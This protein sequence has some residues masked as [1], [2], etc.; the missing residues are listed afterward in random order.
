MPSPWIPLVI[1]LVIGIAF[2]ALTRRVA[3]RIGR[4]PNTFRA[5][6]TAHDFVGRVYRVAGAVLFA[7]VAAR[8]LVPGTDDLLGVV[9]AIATPATAW[10]GVAV[11]IAGALLII[12]AQMQMGASWRIGLDRER[13][14][15]AT[16]GLFTVSRNPTFLGMLA[17]PAGAFLVAPS[18]VI[19]AVLSAAWVAFSVQVRLE[20][21][22]LAR[23]HGPTYETYHAAVPRWISLPRVRRRR[24]ARS[25]APIKAE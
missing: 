23:M 10:G 15:L 18:L 17:L 19:G 9:P 25:G 4:S 5:S 20:E 13:T 24:G 2:S 12:V 16:G 3:R 22:H 14:E 11:M 21:E 1:L 8:A 7:A 6:D